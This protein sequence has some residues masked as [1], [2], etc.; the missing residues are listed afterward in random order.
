VPYQLS[1]RAPDS[2]LCDFACVK[3]VRNNHNN[4]NDVVS[5]PRETKSCPPIW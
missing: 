2:H 4:S 3:D 5:P 1:N